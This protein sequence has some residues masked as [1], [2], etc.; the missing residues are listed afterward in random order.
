MGEGERRV[1]VGEYVAPGAPAIVLM[2]TSELRANLLVDPRE[3][4]DVRPG[5]RVGVRV[6]ARPGRQFEGAVLRVG[7]TTLGAGAV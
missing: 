2:D 4:L 1:E 7:D 5:A 3:A 6:F